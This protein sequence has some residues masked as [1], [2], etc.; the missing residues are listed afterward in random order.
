MASKSIKANELITELLPKLQIIERVIIDKVDDLVW[1][2]PAQRERILELKSEFELELVMIKS[3]I[4]HL[5]ERTQGQYDL[6]RI[7]TDETELALTADEAI[8]IDA[9]WR[10]YQKVDKIAAHFNLSM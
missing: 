9:A 2:A 7:E 3:N 10:L 5:L 4:R 8:A 6:Q 1:K